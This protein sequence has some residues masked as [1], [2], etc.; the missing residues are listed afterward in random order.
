MNN[1]LY[2]ENSCTNNNTDSVYISDIREIEHLFFAFILRKDASCER[3]SAEYCN[4]GNNSPLLVRKRFYHISVMFILSV[5]VFVCLIVC[6]MCCFTTHLT[7]M[8]V[9]G[10]CLHFLRHLPN[11]I[12]PYTNKG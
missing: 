7:A 4:E 10:Y 2:S 8:V 3:A 5:C 12:Q 11:N 6:L 9:S 1:F